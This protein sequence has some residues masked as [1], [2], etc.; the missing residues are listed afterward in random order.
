M[1]RKRQIPFLTWQRVAAGGEVGHW[2]PSPQLRKLGWVNHR[3]GT[4]HPDGTGELAV[5]ERALELNR[6]LAEWRAGRA[7]I[8]P[9]TP[10][11]RKLTFADL[12]DRYRASD[13]FAALAD[14]TRGE[15]ATRLRQLEHWALDGTLPLVQLDRAMVKE[16]KRGLLAVSPATGQPGS[17]YKC[18][19]TLRVL[20]LLLNWAKDEGLAAANPTDGVPIPSTDSRQAKLTWHQAETF[21]AAAAALADPAGAVVARAVRV[22]FWSLQ[23]QADLLALNALAWRELDNLDPR[24][25]A[26]LADPRGIVRGFRLRQQKTRAWI[27]APLPAWLH[28]DVEAAF[29]RSQWLLADPLDPARAIPNWRLQRVARKALRIAGFAGHQFR[30]LRRSGMSFFKDHGALPSNIFAISGHAVLGGRKTI[31]DTYMPPDTPAA[32]AAVA[33]VLRTLTARQAKEAQQ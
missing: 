10:L 2:K 19:S 3:L 6:T 25:R 15:Y 33:A 20:R 16:L 8:Q 9:A 24:D 27:D 22:G 13:E 5:I 7:A 12:A 1:P 21:A 29:A 28:A 4:R 23:R 18:A 14:S 26:A 30:D 11:P 17:K 31:A 32:C